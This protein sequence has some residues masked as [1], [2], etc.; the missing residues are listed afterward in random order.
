MCQP[1]TVFQETA[2][3]GDG[4]SRGKGRNKHIKAFG[5]QMILEAA[6]NGYND[7]KPESGSSDRL[8]A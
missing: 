1:R 2:L 7:A 8:R 5:K 3:M 4:K 6:T